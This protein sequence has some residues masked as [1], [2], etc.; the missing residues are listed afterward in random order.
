MQGRVKGNNVAKNQ[1]PTG[2][3]V[4]IEGTRGED[5]RDAAEDLWQAV[6][7]RKAKGG[8]SPWDASGTFSDLMAGKREDLRFSPRT[9]VLLYASDLVFRLRWQIRPA[10]DQGQTII[11]APYVETVKAFGLAS[12]LPRKWL[13]EVFRFA[14]PAMTTFRIKE[15]KKSAGWKR[16]PLEGFPEFCAATLAKGGGDEEHTSALR[17]QMIEYLDALEGR[18]ACEKLSRK[19]K[20]GDAD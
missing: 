14:P 4:A 3:L 13:A 6:R 11:A 17:K 7:H 10:V 12:G 5:V 1:A 19:I 20:N 18:G 15:R 8:V 2:R 9:L 16:K